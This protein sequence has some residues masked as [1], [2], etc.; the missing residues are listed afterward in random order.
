MLVVVV[1]CFKKC[2]DVLKKGEEQLVFDFVFIFILQHGNTALMLACDC[3]QKEEVDLL[4]SCA[5]N[6][7]IESAVGVY[8][9][10]DSPPFFYV[11]IFYS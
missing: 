10:F 11:G 9:F 6:V 7:N 8:F 2:G 1:V 4:L 3:G 5:A